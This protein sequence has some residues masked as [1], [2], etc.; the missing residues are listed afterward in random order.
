MK[1][2]LQTVAALLRLQARRMTVPEARSALEEAERRVGS[3]ALVH[4]TL[5]QS[6]D[7]SVDFDDIVDRL[8][9]ALADVG[10]TGAEVTTTRVGSFGTLPGEVATTLA[11]V[12]TE[13]LQNAAEHG[14]SGGAGHVEVVAE[15]TPQRVAMVVVDDGVGLPAGFDA[16]TSTSLGLS[17]VRTLVESELGGRLRVAPGEGGGSRFEVTFPLS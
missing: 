17:I 3:I 10:S 7:E 15:R 6:I 9:S 13:L 11:M 12:L 14:F 8:R 5:S 2:N 4:E 1:N 16:A